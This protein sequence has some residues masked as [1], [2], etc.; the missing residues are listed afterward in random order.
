MNDKT[1][2]LCLVGGITGLLS[3]I[4]MVAS[5][6]VVMFHLK[7][8]MVGSAE[9]QLGFIANQPLSGIVHGIGVVSLILIVPMA[10]AMFNLLRSTAVT[11]GFL[12][13]GFA[14]LWIVVEIVGRLSQTAPLRVISELYTNHASGD[15]ALAIYQ[16]SQETWE[17]HS[18]TGAFLCAL[19][20]LFSGCAMAGKPTRL[21]G[22]GLLVAAIAFPIGLLI[23]GVGIQ[24]HVAMRGLAFILLSIALIQN[25]RIREG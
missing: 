6:F 11:R 5:A 10:I 1:T 21:S 14:F 15:M 25:S 18:M 17:A 3:G 13:I 8:T 7:G 23:P 20:C 2:R 19:M 24:P 16:V 9:Q 22:Y 12:A 4:L